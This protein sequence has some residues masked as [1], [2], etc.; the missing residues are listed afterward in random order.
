MELDHLKELWQQQEPEKV[1]GNLRQFLGKKS[2]GPIARMKR[3]L[4]YELIVVI[5]TYGLATIYFFTPAGRLDSLAWIYLILALIF[6]IYFIRKNKL[7][8]EMECMA[9]Q[10]KSNLSRQVATLEK[11]VRYYLI[12]GTAVFPLFIVY[13]YFIVI[14][15]I[16]FVRGKTNSSDGGLT[17]FWETTIWVSATITLTIIIYYLNKWY[18]KKLYGKHINKLKLMLEQ[19]EY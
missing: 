6:I 15:E 14:P 19:M 12:A 1:S 8:N 17:F 4:L 18:V 13:A 10:V 5:I 3:N 16:S 9:C 11:Y 2:R 7:L